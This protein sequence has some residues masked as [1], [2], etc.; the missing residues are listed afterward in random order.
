MRTTLSRNLQIGFGFSLLLLIISSIASYVSIQNLLE[1][2]HLADHS[3]QVVSNLENIIS[4]MK[5][6]ETGQR[7]YLI[8]GQEVFL[9]PYTGSRGSAMNM[10]DKVQNMT[11]DN[12]RQQV[13]LDRIKE[14]ILKRLDILQRLIDKK[15][16]GKV[17][18]ID[19]M[20]PGKLV[21]DDL[22][23]AVNRAETEEEGLLTVRTATLNKFSTFTPLTIVFAAILAIAV[24]IFSYFKVTGDVTARARL[25]QELEDK[26]AETTRRIEIIQHITDQIS[27]G[28]YR[29]R[30]DVHEKDGLGSIAQALNKMAE[31][32]EE[33]FNR[34][35]DNEWMQTGTARLNDQMIGEKELSVLSGDILGFVVAFTASQVGALYVLDNNALWLQSG[36]ALHGAQEKIAMGEGL[37]GQSALTNQE[38]WLKGINDND[39]TVSHATGNIRPQHILVVPVRYEN[40]VKGIIEL[41]SIHP[42]PESMLAF[43][44]N[45]SENIGITLNSAQNHKR[46]QE[47]LEETQ[48]QSEELQAQH[49]DLEN[50]N[51]ELEAHTQKLQTS[52]EELRVQ[53]EELQ[54][55]NLELEERNRI[56]NKRNQEIQ[57]TAEKLEQSTRY[58]SEFM[59]NMSHEL[60]TPLN[61]ILLLSRYL[62]ENS[63]QNLNPEQVESAGVI[64]SS[65]NGLLDLIDELLDLSKIEAGKMELEYQQ[66]SI[67]K[68][69]NNLRT[70]FA[71]V[72]KK[73][74]LDLQIENQLT[75]IMQVETDLMRLEQILK[76][77]L[78]NA[79]KFTSEGRVK[80]EIRQPADAADVLE[81]AVSDTGI[82]IAKEKLGLVF[83][84]FQQAD[85]STKRK[86]GGTGLGLS[87]SRELARLLGG[88]I[89][90][91][92][93]PG[94]GSEF[95]LTLPLDSK[96]RLPTIQAPSRQQENE[97]AEPAS[98]NKVPGKYVVPHIPED[99]ADDRHNLQSGDKITLIIEDDTAF[100]KALLGFTRKRG[101]KGIVAVR[102]DHGITLAQQYQPVAILLDIQ[103]PVKDGWEVMEE[104][105]GNSAT[106]HIPVHIMSSVEA[107]RESRMKGAVDFINK[108]IA[109]EHMKQMFQKLE[110][111][112][113]KNS[114][115][116]LIV[117]ENARHAQALAY[118]LETFNVS[119][120][121]AQSIDESVDALKKK[122]VDCVIMDMG[123]PDKNAYAT[124]DTIKQNPGLE[125]LP[126]IVFTGKHLSTGEES[127]IRRYADT[128]VVKTAHSYQRI[129]DEVTLFL[130]LIE[131]QKQNN[132]NGRR[133]KFGLT[134]DVLKN[135]TV[136]IAD[137]D[138]RNIFSM[139][140]SL[141]KHG[142][143]V[144]SATDGKE[145]LEQLELHP[146][147]AIV[148]MDMMMP[149]MDGYESTARI[150]RHPR[151]K[152]LPIIAETAKAMLGDREKCIAAGASDYISKPVDIDQLTSLL[153]VWLFNKK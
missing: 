146:E 44:K 89:T 129:L 114:K 130:H 41:A 101:Y 151:F 57:H 56:I 45:V 72:A 38:I 26:D 98:Q 131:D 20:Q 148:L 90:L 110:E 46:L 54:Q 71:P 134:N 108:P 119:S 106:R 152:D 40:Q 69:L 1:S 139:T 12:A 32:L 42:Y 78:S 120:V 36:F 61:S 88:E 58:K 137:D 65:G 2:S 147:I 55:T 127:R 43:L 49:N 105:K 48:A 104:L 93:E 92:S 153:Q 133:M 68:L 102:G 62:F 118:F 117:E 87:I 128:I 23:K 64:L 66:I 141:E 86:F 47:L 145:A 59:A 25:Q 3:S 9:E 33:S 5:D 103:L 85:G 76:N 70:L 60:R 21:M 100:A 122:E 35:S 140:K 10:V 31:S 124:L 97:P 121:V 99:I 75:G 51:T 22:R 116:V 15:K 135:K 123:I 13:N 52:D 27:D 136:L 30:V 125:D 73:K 24:S 17:I 107:R 4:T 82:G 95:V 84:A 83:D 16:A 28:D 74:K 29:V 34:L 111:V 150:R 109:M 80:L 113:N 63:D 6:A 14:N 67:D 8:T 50:L 126:I 77:L 81:F 91:T 138:V 144:I 132:G 112:W 53:Q 19:D 149:E 7:G 143:R 115:K 39:I 94:E 142:M 96:A 11:R 79:L 18:T 37:V